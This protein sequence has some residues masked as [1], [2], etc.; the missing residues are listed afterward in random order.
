MAHNNVYRVH[1]GDELILMDVNNA[2]LIDRDTVEYIDECIDNGDLYHR[3]LDDVIKRQDRLIDS[4]EERNLHS[5]WT[6]QF[7][8]SYRNFFYPDIVAENDGKYILLRSRDA[9]YLNN[10]SVVNRILLIPERDVIPERL[11]SRDMFVGIGS[12]IESTSQ[13]KMVY[14][15]IPWKD[16]DFSRCID[17]DIVTPDSF[18][19]MGDVG[20]SILQLLKRGVI[21]DRD[22]LSDFLLTG[23][24]N[25]LFKIRNSNERLQEV[26]CDECGLPSHAGIDK[27]KINNIT[28][29]SVCEH[30]SNMMRKSCSL[31]T[32]IYPLKSFLS[33]SISKREYDYLIENNIERLCSFCTDSLSV[34]CPRCDKVDFIK[35]QKRQQESIRDDFHALRDGYERFDGDRFCGSCY[36]TCVEDMYNSPLRA[37]SQST[38]QN[39]SSEKYDLKRHIGIEN[40]VIADSLVDCDDCDDY[41]EFIDIPIGWEA[42]YDGSLSRGGVEYR[43]NRPIMGDIV[44][45][46][47]SS[48]VSAMDDNYMYADDS[49]GLHIHF[50]ARDM[51]VQSMKSLMMVMMHIEP[52][53]LKTLPG[54]RVNNRYCRSIYKKLSYDSIKDISNTKD[55]ANLYYKHLSKTSIGS[56]HYNEARYHG[57]N[58][59]AR[60]FLG[61]IEFR[62]H[63]GCEDY[64]SIMGWINFCRRI[65]RV[66]NILSGSNQ[67]FSRKVLKE[68]FEKDIQDSQNYSLLKAG[69]LNSEE[70]KKLDVLGGEKIVSYVENR[71]KEN[72]I[73]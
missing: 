43:T 63:E 18:D 30:C 22:M 11:S 3:I 69:S 72:N 67:H 65:I 47:V 48:L 5:V 57:L 32:E 39:G 55:L 44:E 33:I 46:R 37:V 19:F 4:I 8:M 54:N 12:Y 73:I 50:N 17:K 21:V 62:Y 23:L 9:I 7:K 28:M 31:C 24:S 34:S 1:P 15:R 20:N 53:I 36:S 27:V 2:L 60:F 61:T 58:L 51:D 38:F 59:H 10:R 49:C 26:G 56:N 71:I 14:W 40:E 41:E 16:N 52:I 25:R 68:T 42:V 13:F 29:E 45:R 64:D 70:Y 6:V 35:L 66:S